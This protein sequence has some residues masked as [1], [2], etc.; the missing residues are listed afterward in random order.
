MAFYFLAG[1]VAYSNSVVRARPDGFENFQEYYSHFVWFVGWARRICIALFI[2]AVALTVVSVLPSA[3]M[4]LRGRAVDTGDRHH[5]R[6]PAMAGAGPAPAA[7][8]GPEP[9]L[10][11]GRLIVRDPV[12][13]WDT[14]CVVFVAD[15]LAAW[16]TGL[17]ADAGRKRL[18]KLVVGTDQDRALRSAATAAVRLTAEELRPNDHE[19]AG[20][21]GLVISQL[22]GQPTPSVLRAEHQTMLETLQAAIARQLAPLDDSGLTGTGQSSAEVIG[23]PGAVLAEKLTGHLVREILT[24]GS[25]GGPLGPLADQLN[26]DVTHLQGLRLE[27]MLGQLVCEI[28]DALAR[29]SNDPAM[30]TRDEGST[31]PKNT[32]SGGIFYGPVPLGGDIPVPA[33]GNVSEQN[34]AGHV[35]ISY[36]RED[37]DRV[38]QLQHTLQ[39]AGILVWRDTAHLWPGQDWRI[40]IR[41]AITHNALVFIAC[42]SQASLARDKSYQNEEL[43]LAIEQLRLRPVDQPWLIPIRFDECE[44]PD[45]DIGGGRTLSA[46]QRADLFGNRAGENAGL[47]V[48]AIRR[49]L[50]R[51]S[52]EPPRT[53][54]SR[55]NRIPQPTSK[56]ST[57]PEPESSV[58]SPSVANQDGSRSDQ[59]GRDQVPG[60][61]EAGSATSALPA[62]AANGSRVLLVEA[63]NHWCQLYERAALDCGVQTIKVAR[64]L[65][66]AERL[67]DETQFGVALVAVGLDAGDASNIDG[68]HVIDRLGRQA[69]KLA[70]S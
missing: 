70:L 17:L 20:H 54:A 47:L 24:S 4:V 31:R 3:A 40:E 59:V 2:Y 60:V 6:D 33:A 64:N 23:V 30:T 55:R 41:R 11:A 57:P 22:F 65:V 37:S 5:P 53:A 28:R 29:L 49:N 7:W 63:D 44:I 36:V 32:I 69:M 27:G 12:R 62:D 18:T 67:I 58:R 42:F 46:I 10:R 35:F 9:G 56:L 51:R 38:D 48:A 25:Q 66:E 39:E 13:G 43:T 21:V 52:S 14:D 26:H 61:A 50:E 16:L 19:E 68:L 45:R 15:D 8:L 1:V 34:L